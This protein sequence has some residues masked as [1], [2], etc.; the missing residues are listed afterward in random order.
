MTL[1]LF[2]RWGKWMDCVRIS[3]TIPVRYP[4]PPEV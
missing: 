3:K 2:H 4:Y 1:H